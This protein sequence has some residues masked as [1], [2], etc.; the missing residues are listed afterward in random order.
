MV[1]IATGTI[2]A[3]AGFMAISSVFKSLA[4]STIKKY[5]DRK[6]LQIPSIYDLEPIAS[7]YES[8]L[9]DSLLAVDENIDPNLELYLN[10]REFTSFIQF[11]FTYIFAGR[12]L[13][14]SPEL[15][16]E[17]ERGLKSYEY[18]NLEDTKVLYRIITKISID[19]YN[20]AKVDDLEIPNTSS[21]EAHTIISAVTLS[22]IDNQL[23]KL[24]SKE[25]LS[26]N[27]TNKLVERYRQAVISKHGKIQ[28]QSF[29]GA[30]KFNINEL[31]VVPS[32]TIKYEEKD[33]EVVNYPTIISNYRRIVVVGDPG[34]G[35]TT[36]SS[37]LACDLI[38]EEIPI[39]G[40]KGQIIPFIIVLRDFGVFLKNKS[41]SIVEYISETSA[42]VY[43]VP[44]TN[45]VVE[46][47]LDTGH[48]YIIFDGL[49]ELLDT[50][51]RKEIAEKID[52][53]STLYP[54]A[55]ILVTSRVVGYSHNSLNDDFFTKFTLGEFSDAQVSEYVSNWFRLMPSNHD[56]PEEAREQARRFV[57]E[58]NHAHDIRSNP[59]MLGLMCTIYKTESYI[60]RNRPDVYEKCSRMLFKNWDK[61]RGIGDPVKFEFHIDGA[62]A[63]LA[64]KIY[65]SSEMQSGVPERDLI[66]LS[67]AYF[68]EWAY[69]NPNEARS[70]SEDFVGLCKGRAWILAE[71]G[72]SPDGETLFRFTHRTFLE[73]YTAYHIWLTYETI[74]DLCLNLIPRIVA[75]ELDV[76]AE[77]SFQ[78]AAK[79]KQGGGDI[80]VNRLMEA[81]NNPKYI[82]QRQIISSFVSRSLT[83]LVLSPKSIKKN[84]PILIEGAIRGT[85]IRKDTEEIAP[86]YDNSIVPQLGKS[87]RES[88][89]Q[90]RQSIA[91]TLIQ[92]MDEG[93]DEVLLTSIAWDLPSEFS[94]NPV[95]LNGKNGE[96]YPDDIVELISK[97][98]PTLLENY[99]KWQ[100]ACI[101][102]FYNGAISATE[103]L[104]THP[105]SFLLQPAA[106]PHTQKRYTPPS[107]F[108]ASELIKSLTEESYPL[109]ENRFDTF[110]SLRVIANYIRSNYPFENEDGDFDLDIWNILTPTLN[111]EIE[112]SRSLSKQQLND[113]A[114]I[115]ATIYTKPRFTWEPKREDL[116]KILKLPSSL[117]SIWGIITSRDAIFTIEQ[118]EIDDPLVLGWSRSE[119]DFINDSKFDE[120][121]E[122][123]IVE[124]TNDAPL[125]AIE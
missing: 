98:T 122:E 8:Q 73:Y 58:S 5:K 37:K 67:I 69:S 71:A 62:I 42:S 45:V 2:A 93:I 61:S 3:K 92:L 20:I 39:N 23:R 48:L 17:F 50:S 32:L 68:L 115:L 125:G 109:E 77:L 99:T 41:G 83:F 101:A 116:D 120:V 88:R 29:D 27:E 11:T 112:Q 96:S 65:E 13:S 19:I 78:M 7:W 63:Y 14:Q 10:S 12:S 110:D 46:S 79:S 4:T 97:Y 80:I 55:P 82:E 84:I 49:D 40:I 105:L 30:P 38:N 51:Y 106:I 85:K 21:I 33:A 53:F 18:S 111:K 64:G 24:A 103:C 113:L 1:E 6:L 15:E 72:L 22:S 60:P 76:V 66:D 26:A 86:S 25:I 87:V 74:D 75:G 34:G 95:K 114:L 102:L 56:T 100:W 89:D 9:K 57:S 117:K 47:L 104:T 16:L 43:Q 107:L 90:I 52:I 91:S 59:L 54:A 35:K 124:S 44:L 121:P 31:Y 119:I 118:D 28:P 94:L 36:L 81:Y 70:A 123:E 108:I